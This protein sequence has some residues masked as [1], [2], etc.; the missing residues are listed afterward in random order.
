MF[1]LNLGHRWTLAGSVEGLTGAILLPAGLTSARISHSLPA[2]PLTLLLDPQLYLCGLDPERAE[3]QCARLATF[4]WFNVRGVPTYNS[5][6]TGYREWEQS[7]RDTIRAIW[8]GEPPAGDQVLAACLSA[9]DFQ[10]HI[11]CAQIILPSPL[12]VER[13]DEAQIQAEWLDAG[14]EA[15]EALD[16][17]QPIIATVALSE[18]VINTT[19]F[20]ALG[21]LDTVVDQVSSRPGL[22]GIYVVIAQTS[23][24]HPFELSERVQRAYLY[25]SNAFRRKGYKFVMTNFAD[26]F[27]LV[28]MGAGATAFGTGPSH[29]LRRLCLDA[30]KE[31]RGGKAL[32]HL[33]SHRV[34]AELLSQTDLDVVVSAGITSRLRD[35]TPHSAA[36]MDTLAAGRSASTLPDWA[37]SQNN[38]GT[39]H[40]HFVYRLSS[41]ARRVGRMD[42]QDRPDAIRDWLI[43]A[44]ANQRYVSRRLSNSLRWKTAPVDAWL[45]A[46]DDLPR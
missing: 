30:F 16:V 37:E 2:D 39:A 23:N 28:C 9:V 27:G 21:F 38:L 43:M 13:E 19:A 14:L 45:I 22:D 10:A 1:Y 8:P 44:G 34:A 46:F 4:P 24:S 36:L 17:S 3:K 20:D 25:L 11:R 15:A 12:I 7:I 18:E 32:P 42:P 41:E 35:R 26:V 33:Y 31:I 5:G 40:S 6:S 29:A